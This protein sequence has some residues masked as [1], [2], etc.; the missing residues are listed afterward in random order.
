M[1]HQKDRVVKKKL[2]A[3]IDFGKILVKIEDILSL[4]K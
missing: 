4:S 2:N 3:K 1:Q